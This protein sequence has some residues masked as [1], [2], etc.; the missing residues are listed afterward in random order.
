M[1]RCERERRRGL[2]N[3]SA[4]P[5]L[6]RPF[7]H[8]PRVERNIGAQALDE[9]HALIGVE[10]DLVWEPIAEGPDDEVG[11]AGVLEAMRLRILGQV[12]DAIAD[13][14]RNALVAMVQRTLATHDDQ[15][16]FLED[17]LVPAG[18]EAARSHRLNGQT[19]RLRAHRASYVCHLFLAFP[20]ATVRE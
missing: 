19:D 15:Y 5:T 13:G 6:F 3:S 18:R 14:H 12:T 10:R 8:S 16:F 2:A 9:R 1:L 11:F 4:L 7:A 20:P 17:V